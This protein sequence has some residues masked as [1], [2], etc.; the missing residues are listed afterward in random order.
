MPDIADRMSVIDTDSHV[1]EPADLW[2]SRMP[3]RWAELTP[4]IKATDRPSGDIWVIGDRELGSGLGLRPGRVEGTVPVAPAGGR[5]SRPCR[6]G[7]KGTSSKTRRIRNPRPG[8]LSEYFGS[9]HSDTH[10]GRRS[11]LPG[12]VLQCLQR[13]PCR[14]RASCAREIHSDYGRTALRPR[15]VPTRDRAMHRNGSQGHFVL[16][17]ARECWPPSAP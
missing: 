11:R 1:S 3:Q 5:G 4:R 10:G 9:P 17:R 8:A 6:V 7:T 12:S 14:V 13:F 2:Q 15:S 16:E